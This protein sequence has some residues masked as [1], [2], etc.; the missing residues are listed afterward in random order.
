MHIGCWPSHTTC[1]AKECHTLASLW[2]TVHLSQCAFCC[3]DRYHDPKQT[4][5]LWLTIPHHNISL[6][7]VRM[8]TQ[9]RNLKA[10]TQSQDH[11]WIQQACSPWLAQLFS[12]SAFLYSPRSP[13]QG[14][15][16]LTV[17]GRLPFQLL[18]NAPMPTD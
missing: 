7:E 6:G 2:F 18:R 14:M 11:K 13:A 9:N 3:C 8:G 4:G 10:G 12:C 1:W 17:G 16:S 15:V 5:F